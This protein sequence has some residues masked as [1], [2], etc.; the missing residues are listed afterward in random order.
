MK[1]LTKEEI[2]AQG[3]VE[4]GSLDW[5]RARLGKITSSNVHFVMKAPRAT[6]ANPNPEGFSDTAKGYLYQV[7]AER[8]LVE[9]FVNN[10]LYFQEY[11]DRVDI[12]NRSIRYGSETEATAREVYAG[13]TGNEVIECG[14]VNHSEI[15]NYGDSPDGLIIDKEGSPIGALEI[16]CPKP[17][18]FIK[19]QDNIKDAASLK[20][21]K[22]EYYWQC[23]SH[24]ECNNVAW[25]DFV[26]FD[27]MQR[28]GFICIRIERNDEDIALMKERIILANAEIDKL[29]NE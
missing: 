11:L 7:A 20:E 22:P 29:I 23:Q 8:N 24:C 9:E 27:K 6:K 16:K 4:Q 19:Y 25:C 18:T 15:S 26:V 5:Y 28:K 21:V 17:D 2:D 1:E 13:I 14:F 3:C 10:D 12:S